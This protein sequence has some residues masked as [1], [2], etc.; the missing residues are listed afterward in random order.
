MAAFTPLA[1]LIWQYEGGQL[2]ANPVRQATLYTGRWA[3]NLLVLS[4]ACTPVYVLTGWPAIVRVRKSLGL[5]AFAYAALHLSIFAWLDFG[6]DWPLI[7]QEVAGRRFIWVGLGAFVIL[8]PLALTSTRGWMRR[9]GR[10]WKRLHRLAYLAAGLAV[11]HFLWA[12]KADRR[13]PIVYGGV[14]AVLLVLRLPP[15]QKALKR[16]TS[17]VGFS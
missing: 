7:A 5:Y 6:L 16:R 15:V 13:E 11:W 1:W 8:V 4:L 12:V 3:L 2:S 14:L 17:N 10:W 9:L